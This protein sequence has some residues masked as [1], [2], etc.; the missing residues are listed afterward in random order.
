[1]AQCWACGEVLAGSADVELCGDGW[2]VVV[3]LGDSGHAVKVPSQLLETLAVHLNGIVGALWIAPDR[4]SQDAIEP[5]HHGELSGE[6][7]AAARL[8]AGGAAPRMGDRGRRRRLG[9]CLPGTGD[10]ACAL[11]LGARVASLLDR[12]ELDGLT[13]LCVFAMHAA[14]QLAA[15]Q[16]DPL[17]GEFTRACI[18]WS[19]G[20]RAP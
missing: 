3:T 1:M 5:E 12:K 9:Q 7:V 6:A 19:G 2:S 20:G 4:A 11:K 18:R 14:G 16:P 17:A 8:A 13:L 10:A 15:G